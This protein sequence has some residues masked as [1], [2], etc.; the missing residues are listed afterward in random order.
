VDWNN[1]GKTDL[2]AGD[3]QGNVWLFINIGTKKEPK[4][5][6]GRRVEADGKAIG[7]ARRTYKTVNGRRVVDKTI[8]ASHELAKTYSK[9]HMAD[10]DG[11]GLK[12]LLI[13]HSKNIVFYKNT[14]TKSLPRFQAPVTIEPPGGSFA[15]RPSP[16]VVDW[17]GDGKKD[18]L[19]ATEPRKIFFYRN[20]GTSKAPKLAKP[21]VLDLKG[22]GFADS[23]RYRIE[24]TDWNNDGKLDILAGSFYSIRAERKTGGNVWLFLGK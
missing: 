1:D 11:D 19:V 24:V 9:L 8:A 7:P 2:I 18:L 5:D 14:G 12:D 22:Q 6:T 3:T 10:W 4:L 15:H 21:T 17:D 20:I 16:Y 23:Y 13:G